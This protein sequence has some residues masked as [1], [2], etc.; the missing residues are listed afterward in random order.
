MAIVIT[1]FG[2]MY[3][4]TIQSHEIDNLK[5]CAKMA[6]DGIQISLDPEGYQYVKECGCVIKEQGANACFVHDKFGPSWQKYW[7]ND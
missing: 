2:W 3:L 1:C 4:F 7:R 5:A 6:N